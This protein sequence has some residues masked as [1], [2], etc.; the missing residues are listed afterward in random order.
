MLKLSR[1][2]ISEYGD[3]YADRTWINSGYIRYGYND[4]YYGEKIKIDF[5]KHDDGEITVDIRDKA[6]K[7][8]TCKF[9]NVK[10]LKEC[11]LTENMRLI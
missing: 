3:K 9:D 10:G 6:N 11:I 7:G 1:K 2:H 4:E 5:E 8:F